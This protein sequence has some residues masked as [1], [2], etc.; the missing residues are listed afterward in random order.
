MDDYLNG[1]KPKQLKL[2]GNE[3]QLLSN[4]LSTGKLDESQ[5]P[6]EL[7]ADQPQLVSTSKVM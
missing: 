1:R 2:A 7:G 5:Y 3:Q 4:N 6:P